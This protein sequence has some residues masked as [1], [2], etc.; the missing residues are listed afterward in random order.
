MLFHTSDEINNILTAWNIFESLQVAALP[1]ILYAIQNVLIQHG[2][3][4]LNSLT[5]NLLNQTKVLQ[6]YHSL[7]ICQTLSAALWLYILMDQRQS[8][9]QLF[10]LFLI[11]LAGTGFFIYFILLAVILNLNPNDNPKL[12]EDVDETQS[13]L[14][15][16]FVL[17]ASMLSGVSAALT[18]KVI[19][20]H[21]YS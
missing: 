16:V 1:A 18:Q 8:Y 3:L 15:V 13:R 17:V 4:F 9:M 19:I 11:S 7:I 12:I 2:Y 6:L 21:W 14:G 5:F 20:I 10:A